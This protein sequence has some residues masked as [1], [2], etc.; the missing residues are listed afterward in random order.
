MPFE[1]VKATRL[2]SRSKKHNFPGFI[3]RTKNLK[4]RCF[5]GTAAL[6]E[7][8]ADALL[9]HFVSYVDIKRGLV[10]LE[11]TTQTNYEGAFKINL[12]PMKKGIAKQYGF[13]HLDLAEILRR[14]FNEKVLVLTDVS[15]TYAVELAEKTNGK[16]YMFEISALKEV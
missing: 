2:F 1:L 7:L 8:R 9:G 6:Y 10:M 3:F 16:G 5:I 13:T 11:P 14:N 12:S 15:A 4:N